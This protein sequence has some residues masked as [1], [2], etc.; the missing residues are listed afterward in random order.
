MLARICDPCLLFLY[1]MARIINPRQQ[2]DTS[3]FR[4]FKNC[5]I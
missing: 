5:S 2:R 3:N 1:Y 4:N